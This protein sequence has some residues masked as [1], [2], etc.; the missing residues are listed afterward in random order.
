MIGIELLVRNIPSSVSISGQQLKKEKET[1]ETLVLGASQ[2]K[3]AINPEF[4]SSRASLT[5]AGTRQG[6]K[7]DYYL[8]KDLHKQLPNLKQVVIG[9]TYRHFESRPNS[10]NFWKYRSHLLYYNVNAFER[11]TYFKD[12]LLFLGNT[13]FYSI[14]LESYYLNN[15]A[16]QY[17]TF[18]FQLKGQR[19]LFGSLQYDEKLIQ[20][21]FKANNY[22]PLSKQY[23]SFTTTWF[24]KVLRYC[25]E[26]NLEVILTKTPTY[27][28][29]REHQDREVLH[30]RDS[31]VQVVLSQ[32]PNI[33][34]F[35]QEESI[36]FKAIHY[37]NENHLNPS[38]AEIFTKKLDVFLQE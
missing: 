10:P 27:Q 12:K 35:D 6:H 25:Q 3:R 29:Y 36:D 26:N 14:Q 38:G 21:N 2:N 22:A 24:H 7:T 23:L 32:Y 34:L 31:I 30:R 1:I 28:L 16:S 20:E 18:G 11:P 15:V 33:K 17:N 19:D 13:K 9:A 8:L 5:V 4:L 37:L